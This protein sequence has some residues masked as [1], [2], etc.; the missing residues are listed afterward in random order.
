SSGSLPFVLQ[1]NNTLNNAVSLW[2]NGSLPGSITMYYKSNANN[3]NK[4]GV[5][6]VSGQ[7]ITIN[8]NKNLYLSFVVPWG[9]SGNGSLT[10]TYVLSPG[11]IVT[12]NYS[13]SA[14]P[15]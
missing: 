7:K 12:Y 3:N 10:F 2:I 1:I 13:V 14:N 8:K 5:P 15:F 11:V 6:W 9:S 4:L